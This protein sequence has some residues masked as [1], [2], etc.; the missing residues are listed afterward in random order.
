M[1]QLYMYFIYSSVNTLLYV[2]VEKHQPTSLTNRPRKTT[3]NSQD[4]T[5][6]VHPKHQVNRVSH[7]PHMQSMLLWHGKNKRNGITPQK[8]VPEQGN[9]LHVGQNCCLYYQ[10]SRLRIDYEV[11]LPTSSFAAD[12]RGTT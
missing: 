8:C 9:M 6:Q 1:L 12:C 11:S 3:S 10:Y 4:D 5:C 2:L 7:G